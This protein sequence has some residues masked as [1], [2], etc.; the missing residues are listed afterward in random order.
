M[1]RKVKW[2]VLVANLQVSP[3]WEEAGKE[4]A[5]LDTGMIAWRNGTKLTR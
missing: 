2:K 1:T 5:R 4:G 3:A